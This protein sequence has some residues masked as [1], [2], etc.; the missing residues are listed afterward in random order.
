MMIFFAHGE[1]AHMS[2]LEIGPLDDDFRGRFHERVTGEAI[3]PS[4]A[5][6]QKELKN[7]H[8]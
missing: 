1:R 8:P 7:A 3:E 2:E 6:I 4:R 5:D